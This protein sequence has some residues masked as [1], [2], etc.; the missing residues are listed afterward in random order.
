MSLCRAGSALEFLSLVVHAPLP[1]V[2]ATGD[3]TSPRPADARRWAWPAPVVSDAASQA[4]LFTPHC[5]GTRSTSHRRSVDIR[6]RS[7][8]HRPHDFWS[9]LAPAVGDRCHIV[10]YAVPLAGAPSAFSGAG[11]RATCAG[12]WAPPLTHACSCRLRRSELAG[13]GLTPPFFVQR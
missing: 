12:L 4:P 5:R 1:H 7:C 11:Q 9:E 10:P 3:Q 13:S 6:G 2:L 8:G